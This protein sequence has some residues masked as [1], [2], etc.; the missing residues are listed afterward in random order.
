MNACVHPAAAWMMPLCYVWLRRT[1]YPHIS[2]PRAIVDM[3]LSNEVL[4]SWGMHSCRH[5][6]AS[7]LVQATLLWGTMH[8]IP[9]L[10]HLTWNCIG[11][12]GP[13][14]A[15][16]STEWM[17]AGQGEAIVRCVTTLSFCTLHFL[18][19]CWACDSPSHALMLGTY[20]FY[21]LDIQTSDSVRNYKITELYLGDI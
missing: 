15:Y 17:G 20:L 4:C 10:L 2:T 5:R 14:K 19:L 11:H 16:E 6:T 18:P 13:I 9:N 1:I 12:C 8:D 3:T 7:K 21:F